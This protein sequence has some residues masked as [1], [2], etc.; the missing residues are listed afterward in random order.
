MPDLSVFTL[1]VWG[2][3]CGISADREPRIK[4]ISHFLASNSYDIVL[5]QELWVPSDY[6]SLRSFTKD[7]L[8]Y[9]HFFDNGI[10]G[11]G[12]C[13]LSKHPILVTYIFVH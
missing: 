6:T 9:Q 10:I 4:A 13:V 8:P 2:I 1:N 3:G 7:V 11:S 5:L 12:T